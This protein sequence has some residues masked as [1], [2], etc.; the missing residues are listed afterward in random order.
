M[1]AIENGD[2]QTGSSNSQGVGFQFLVNRVRYLI[3]YRRILQ[4]TTKSVRTVNPDDFSVT[5]DFQFDEI[6]GGCCLTS[7]TLLPLLYNYV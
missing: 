2:S 7:P 6:V 5:N 3:S 1:F 4:L